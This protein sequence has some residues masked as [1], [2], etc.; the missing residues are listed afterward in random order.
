MDFLIIDLETTGL[1]ARTDEI[2][3]I[4]AVKVSDGRITD[5]FQTFVK[6][7]QQLS[8][9]I[10]ELTGITPEMLSEAPGIDHAVKLLQRFAGGMRYWVAHNKSFESA[11]LDHLL[12]IQP[13]WLDSIDLAKIVLPT[14]R[15]F[16]LG[17]LTDQYN[18]EHTEVHRALGDAMATARLLLILLTELS[19][20]SDSIW[21]D[22]LQIAA[23]VSSPLTDLLLDMQKKRPQHNAICCDESGSGFS[24]IDFAVPDAEDEP[25]HFYQLP[26]K[27][28]EDFFDNLPSAT[29]E[30]RAEQIE[31]S[32]MVADAF[33]RHKVLLAEAG[34]GTG[35]SLAYLLPAVLFAKGSN[36]Q[37]II[38]TNTIN[39][40]E[41]LLAKDIPLLQQEL[42]EEF[43]AVV[44]KGRSN[45]LC[46]RK[47]QYMQREADQ[48]TLPLFLRIAHWLHIT[49]TGDFSE[50]NLWESEN[51]ILQKLNAANE[52]CANFNCRFSHKQCFVTRIRR[53]AQAAD[54]IIVN[55]S[56]LLTAGTADDDFT[57]VLPTV[58]NIIIDEAHQLE[59]VAQRQ[60]SQEFSEHRINTV[61]GKLWQRSRPHELLQ[62]IRKLPNTD[63][64]AENLQK[65]INAYQEVGPAAY[66][67]T[68]LTDALFAAQTRPDQ[69]YL[70]ITHQRYDQI[71]WQPVENALSNLYFVL[72]QLSKALSSLLSEINDTND[73]YFSVDMIAAFQSVKKRLAEL[74]ITAQRVI[75]GR[76]NE[77]DE[78]CVIW[79]E[80][81][82]QWSGGERQEHLQWW[83]APSDIRPILNRGLYADKDAMILTSA[84]MTNNNFSYF[85]NELGL[86]RQELAIVSSILPSPF[87]YRN[88]SMLLLA[89]DIDD[90]TQAS[91]ISI[92]QQLT[93]AIYK[94]VTAAGGKTLVLFTSYQQLNGVYDL[95]HPMLHGTNIHLLA[96]GRSGSRNAIV[97]SMKRHP[98]SCI[99]GVNSFWEG[100]DIKGDSL[101]LLII[102]RLPF[103]PPDTPILEAKFENIRRQ[104]GNPFRD[105]SLPQAIIRFKQGFGRLIRSKTDRGICCVLDQRIWNKKSYGKLFVNALP[106]LP[107]RCCSTD[108]MADII[109]EY[110]ADKEHF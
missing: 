103:S 35:K 21:R 104:G 63:S 48:T 37:I 9:E 34:T 69:R 58:S 110:L 15:Y 18:I 43:S 7:H 77:T 83:V 65:L 87:D 42:D 98:N 26:L 99:L 22:M 23:N 86:D 106:D 73:A 25:D 16:R 11:F 74:L 54:I 56:L 28:I 45:Y 3:E 97:G 105:Y 41:Q 108:Q 72:K 71:I 32:Q 70:R 27:R 6:P 64:I 13:L 60:L 36:Q 101:S 95:L 31:M 2:I 78:E 82:W 81:A 91:S 53:E 30:R 19:N 68:R 90:Y 62:T 96:H 75:D 92:L 61:I 29:Y 44:L 93:D 79:L 107:V 80:R 85:I 94:L 51:E 33:N 55:H 59:S 8:D 52:T 40:Q 20:L 14:S 5:S 76:D 46:W 17:Y 89:N 57:G 66:T 67:F 10:S 100:V 49:K 109:H 84:T 102:V 47:W 1:N 88:N 38:S 12:D 4:G 24:S 50:M 39:L